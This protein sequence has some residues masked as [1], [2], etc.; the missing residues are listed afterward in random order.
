MSGSS[1]L[2]VISHVVPTDTLRLAAHKVDVLF[3]TFGCV[4]AGGNFLNTSRS[5][6]EF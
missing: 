2:F 4:I 3:L 1:L 5:H 6:L